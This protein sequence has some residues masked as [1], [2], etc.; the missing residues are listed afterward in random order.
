MVDCNMW[1]N[2]SSDCSLFSGAR[3]LYKIFFIKFDYFI[4]TERKLK[5]RTDRLVLL[6]IRHILL[7]DILW[8]PALESALSSTHDK[9]QQFPWIF[10]CFLLFHH[11]HAYLDDATDNKWMNNSGFV[12]KFLVYIETICNLLPFSLNCWRPFGYL[13]WC[14]PLLAGALCNNLSLN[15]SIDNL[16][17]LVALAYWNGWKYWIWKMLASRTVWMMQLSVTT[18]RRIET[19]PSW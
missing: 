18:N 13:G 7:Y 3:C 17:E 10:R 6:A 4:H 14:S 12:S 2:L 8:I 11:V 19:F 9:P 5:T 1:L 15:V 16:L